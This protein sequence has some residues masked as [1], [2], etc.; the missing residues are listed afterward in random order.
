MTSLTKEILDEMCEK[1]MKRG[2]CIPEYIPVNPKFW[3]QL[4]EYQRWET[5]VKKLGP[6]L[7]KQ[8]RLKRKLKE[9]LGVYKQK[10]PLPN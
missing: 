7:E 5:W 9:R 2:M 6:R 10:L 4:L 3:S 1:I 8:E